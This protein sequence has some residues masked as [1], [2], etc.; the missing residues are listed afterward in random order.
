[1]ASDCEDYPLENV[2]TQHKPFLINSS[3]TS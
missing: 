3:N 1:M 2:M